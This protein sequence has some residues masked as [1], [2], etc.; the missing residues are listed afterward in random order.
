MELGG[1]EMGHRFTRWAW[2]RSTVGGP[3]RTSNSVA[4]R[5]S[6]ELSDPVMHDDAPRRGRQ[7]V[8]SGPGPHASCA[9]LQP[10]V[11]LPVTGVASRRRSANVPSRIERPMVIFP[12]AISRRGPPSW[13]FAY[14][15]L[16]AVSA[17][18]NVP[19]CAACGCRMNSPTH[20]AGRAGG[21]AQ[22]ERNESPHGPRVSLRRHELSRASRWHSHGARPWP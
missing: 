12:L 6:P 13:M 1:R 14:T 16:V 21:S 15:K 19:A 3:G 9:A 2:M 4:L 7:D 22:N 8:R 18:L 5:I 17:S 10:Q 11:Q 20:L